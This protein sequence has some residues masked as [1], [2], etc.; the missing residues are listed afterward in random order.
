MQIEQWVRGCYV[1]WIR[2]RISRQIDRQ[3][4]KL[5]WD[6][7]G[8]W[9]LL[10]LNA[11]SVSQRTNLLSRF[12][13][14][15]WYVEH[16]HK[17]SEIAAVCRAMA[18]RSAKR[19]EAFLEAGCWQGG[20]SAKFS[21][22]CKMFGYQLKIYDSFCG[23]EQMQP[24]E[25]AESY[26]F[27]GEYAAPES[28]LSDNLALFGEPDVCSVHKGWFHETLA[29]QAV[30]FPVGIAFLDCDLAKGTKEALLGI[31]PALAQ[32]GW[33]FSQDFHIKPVRDLIYDQATWHSFGKGTPAVTQ[34]GK[35]LAGIRF[36]ERAH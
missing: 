36:R 11:L 21:I 22:I 2:P 25:L 13:V 32:D 18:E 16:S 3:R 5:I 4:I 35:K 29:L 9:P 8:Y 10:S 24:E 17:P 6:V 26:D 19:G 20:S 1:R 28:V 14:I 30:P 31:V 12:L 34:L 7:W 15:D 27:S 33:I 23:V